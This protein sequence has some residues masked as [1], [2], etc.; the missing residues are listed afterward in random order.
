MAHKLCIFFRIFPMY[1][2]VGFEYFQKIFHP[3][4]DY[5]IYNNGF[6]FGV[7]SDATIEQI[8]VSTQ[9]GIYVTYHVFAIQVFVAQPQKRFHR[10]KLSPAVRAPS[11]GVGSPVPLD[12]RKRADPVMVIELW[13]TSSMVAV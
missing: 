1:M 2:H 7:F 4:T 5:N 13:I 10:L 12:W 6:Y 3:R 9:S 11:I 8:C